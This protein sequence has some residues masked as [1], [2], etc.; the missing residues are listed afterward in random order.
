VRELLKSAEET[1]DEDL[2]FTAHMVA[3]VTYFWL[4]NLLEAKQHGELILSRYD[5]AR[6]AHI[7]HTLNHDPKTLTGLYASHWVWMLGQPDQAVAVAEDRDAHARAV[8]HPFDR[9]F[10]LTTGSHVYEYR[11]DP[12]GQFR[13]A[14]DAETLGR[15]NSLPFISEVLAPNF[16]GVSLIWEGRAQEG[17]DYLQPGLGVWDFVGAGV[18]SPYG[19]SVMAEGV[20]LL[21]DIDGAL[22]LID[23]QIEQVERPGWEERSHYAEILRLKGWM[24]TLK[25]DLA[26][27]EKNYL[28]SLDWAREQQAKS[29]ELRTSTSLARLWQGQGKGKEALDLLKPVYDWFTEGFDT[30]DLKEAKAL[31]EELAA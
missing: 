15:E 10:A 24:L 25:D 28:A 4:G 14:V 27:A 31:L 1:Q 3:M 12:Q 17:L 16:K 23:E 21:G 18:W 26:G 7:V 9:G 5:S 2:F 8:G 13:S 11:G 19:K 20:A 6:H 29:W 30:K 22:E